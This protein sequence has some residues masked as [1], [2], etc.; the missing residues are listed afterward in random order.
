MQF[1]EVNKKIPA[2]KLL[3]NLYEIMYCTDF[4]VKTVVDGLYKW[5]SV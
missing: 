1:Y 5:Q 4:G 3:T 2:I